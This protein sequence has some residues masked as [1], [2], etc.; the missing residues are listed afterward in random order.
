MKS[1]N[2]FAS[3]LLLAILPLILAGGL[4]LFAFFAFIKLD[5]ATLNICRAKQLEVQ[6]KVAKNL[7]RLLRLNS[8]ALRL[9]FAQAHAEKVLAAALK[10]ALPPAIAAAEARLLSIKLRRQSLDLRQKNII[11]EANLRVQRGATGLAKEL[12]YEAQRHTAPLASWFQGR[13]SLGTS[14]IPSLAVKADLPEVAPLYELLPE[15]AE[16]Q[17]W[18]QRWHL[19][20]ATTSWVRKY[21]MF[22]QRF[23]R[24]CTTSLYPDGAQWMARM[25]KDKSSLRAFY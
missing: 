2:G 10:T 19:D 22:K 8:Q 15:F 25:K 6:N 1:E 7:E 14:K 3:I 18:T 17:A 20:F 16:A 12:H 24:A 23:A 13:L 11:D 9:R 5:L 4:A 21:L